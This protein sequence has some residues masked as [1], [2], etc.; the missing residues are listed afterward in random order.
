MRRFRCR[1]AGLTLASISA[2][3]S[4]RHGRR[5][6]AARM[7]ICALILAAAAA[8]SSCSSGKATKPY[9]YKYVPGRT[10]RISGG[11]AEPPRRAPAAVRR[12]IAAGNELIG[13]PYKYGGGHRSIWDSGYDCSGSV[14]YVLNRAGLLRGTMPSSGFLNYGKKGEGDW[15]TV[16]T[17]RGHVFIVVAGLRLDTGGSSGRTGPRWKPQNRSTN[18]YYMRHPPGL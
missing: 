12:A 11:Y 7:V 2:G 16:Y 18:G 9:S 8:F 17:K 6:G 15:I 1:P 14:S 3:V 10:A 4:G 13:K 5:A